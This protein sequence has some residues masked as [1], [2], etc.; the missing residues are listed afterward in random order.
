MEPY[1]YCSTIITNITCDSFIVDDKKYKLA[2]TRSTTL[3]GRIF[4]VM[5][6]MLLKE[7]SRLELIP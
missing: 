3:V 2:S 1:I 5:N 6:S 7:K 4:S